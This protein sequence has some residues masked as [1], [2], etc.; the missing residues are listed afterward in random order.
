M[1]KT[2]EKITENMKIQLLSLYEEGKM[3]SE[4]ARILKVS[5]NAIYY[6]RKKLNLKSKF[7]YSKISKINTKREPNWLSFLKGWIQL[8]TNT[9][10]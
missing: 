3:D 9:M 6:W 10:L 7:T 8:L 4:I 5:S 2:I 1:G